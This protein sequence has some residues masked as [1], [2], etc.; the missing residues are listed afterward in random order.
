MQRDP[1]GYVDGLNLGNYQNS[2]SIRHLDPEGTAFCDD[3]F[4]PN[5][6]CP[7]TAR[8]CTICNGHGSVIICFRPGI[9]GFQPNGGCDPNHSNAIA[10]C[11]CRH[12]MVHV[13]DL[14]S[15]GQGCSKTP[16]GQPTCSDVQGGM[17][18]NPSGYCGVCCVPCTEAAGYTEE[19]R[20]LE[21]TNPVPGSPEQARLDFVKGKMNDEKAKCNQC[22]QLPQ[23]QC[24]CD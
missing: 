22:K 14:T 3:A 8:A 16:S 13:Q 7:L 1:L 11:A 18:S 20:C 21:S 5:G 4:A 24:S 2:N 17:P 10:K 15:G 12:E 9:I 6:P 19:V 23:A